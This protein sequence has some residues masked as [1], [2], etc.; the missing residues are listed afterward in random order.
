MPDCMAFMKLL[1]AVQHCVERSAFKLLVT[2]A[3]C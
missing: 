2:I 3:V 1:D